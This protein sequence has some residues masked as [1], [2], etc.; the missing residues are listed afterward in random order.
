MWMMNK[1]LVM[2]KILMYLWC[3]TL[4]MS[5]MSAAEKRSHSFVYY[6]DS[7]LKYRGPIYIYISHSL[8]LW[9]VYVM[10]R[11]SSSAG[12]VMWRRY[13]NMLVWLLAETVVYTQYIAGSQQRLIGRKWKCLGHTLG[14]G[15][16][17]IAKQVLRIWWSNRKRA[18]EKIWRK[19]WRKQASSTLYNYRK[20]RWQGD[21]S[22][23]QN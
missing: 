10:K 22:Q 5:G 14:R 17:C 16:D 3:F 6:L 18:M 9:D 23:R 15:N 2:V 21:G 8:R 1:N 12:L 13:G 4:Q 7:I 20:M 11:V 19:K